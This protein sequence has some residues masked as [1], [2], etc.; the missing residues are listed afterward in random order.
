LSETNF[1][2]LRFRIYI[3]KKQR[4]KRREDNSLKNEWACPNPKGK[5]GKTNASFNP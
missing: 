4:G 1:Y 5:G 2:D 3:L